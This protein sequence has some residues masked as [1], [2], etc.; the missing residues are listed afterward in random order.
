MK[1]FTFI[2]L[3]MMIMFSS[4][5]KSDYGTN[6]SNNESVYITAGIEQPTPSTKTSLGDMVDGITPVE[7][8]LSPS[9]DK[10]RV[11]AHDGEKAGRYNTFTL[12]EVKEGVGVFKGTIYNETENVYYSFYPM[13]AI[14]YSSMKNFTM[15]AKQTYVENNISTN[16]MPMAAMN[17]KN[18]QMQFKNLCGILRLQMK[19]NFNVKKVEVVS[20]S[21]ISSSAKVTMNLGELPS[22]KMTSTYTTAKVM[23]LDC[24]EAGVELNSETATIF[25][26]V[27]PP[28]QG[29]DV[30]LTLKFYYRSSDFVEVLIP[31]KPLNKIERN[32]ITCMPVKTIEKPYELPYLDEYGVDHGPGVKIDGLVW[33]PV[34]CGYHK[35]NF[36][37]GKL[38]QWGRKYGQGY[39]D[40]GGNFN[41]AILPIISETPLAYGAEADDNTFYPKSSEDGN[42]GQWMA[43]NGDAN[44]F[45]DG[46][47]WNDLTD[48]GEKIGN[49]CPE[50]WRVP[51]V[52][53]LLSL[54][55]NHSGNT[56]VKENGVKGIYFSGSK[57]FS[58]N[59][60]AKIFV[61]FA[62]MRWASFGS[63][64]YARENACHFWTA[65]GPVN[66]KSKKYYK[67][68]G[69]SSIYG[70]ASDLGAA[71]AVRCVHN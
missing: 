6:L 35:D 42:N 29:E 46:I 62:G 3:T 14:G 64:P 7:W 24:G 63:N 31:N 21:P 39:S 68:K 60:E 33:S 61:A 48:R 26:I 37:Y 9:P 38:Y 58:M 30:S 49:P 59:M 45:V 25:N 66:G 28:S 1:N 47:S 53:E 52:E 69:T 44:A 4:C 2:F 8:T 67:S 16:T 11:Y 70:F 55:K 27:L 32:K 13:S 20:K 23:T 71:A 22:L 65:D 41:D 5:T 56:E 17:N 50:G 19:G 12:S 40:N 18:E 51:T 36:K 54:A 34:N 43:K 10:I 15:P 57:S